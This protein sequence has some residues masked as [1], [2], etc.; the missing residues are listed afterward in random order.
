MFR[1]NALVLA[2]LAETS[3]HPIVNLSI[4]HPA[5]LSIAHPIALGSMYLLAALVQLV[6][7][8]SSFLD[9]DLRSTNLI[10]RLFLV[11]QTVL[12]LMYQPYVGAKPALKVVFLR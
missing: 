6:L 2:G 3:L 1:V 10:V 5:W 8:A 12:V 4:L 11:L 7:K 9:W